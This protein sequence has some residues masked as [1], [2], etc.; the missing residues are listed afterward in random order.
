[1]YLQ[2]YNRLLR[3]NTNV[4]AKQT[5][6]QHRIRYGS[7]ENTNI[8]KVFHSPTDAVFIILE[9]SKIYIKTY[10]KNFSYMFPSTTI[11][12]EPTLELG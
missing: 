11:I 2:V 6:V 4:L 1:L 3:T 8:L 5:Y 10:T 7:S 12:R 9:N